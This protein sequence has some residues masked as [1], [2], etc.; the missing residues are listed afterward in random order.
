[1]TQIIDEINLSYGIT[2]GDVAARNFLID[3]QT[4]RLLLFDF[5]NGM[6]IGDPDQNPIL[7]GPLGVDGAIST[8]DEPIIFDSSFRDGQAY[9]QHQL[10][11]IEKMAE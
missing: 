9:W 7:F 3:P 11:P 10:S 1:M 2:H 4:K 6:Q 8:I 5:Y